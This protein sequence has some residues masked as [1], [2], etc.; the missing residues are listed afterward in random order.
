MT[1][2]FKFLILAF[3]LL[4]STQLHAQDSAANAKTQRHIE[5]NLKDVNKMQGKID[6]KQKKIARQERKIRRDEAKRD[7]RMKRVNKEQKKI[8]DNQ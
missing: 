3:V 5:S 8:N 6:K 4:M 2:K 1:R 7:K